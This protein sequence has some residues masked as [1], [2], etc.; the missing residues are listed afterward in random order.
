MINFMTLTFKILFT[1][2]ALMNWAVKIH[3]TNYYVNAST[4]NNSNT[5]L[6]AE[7]ALKTLQ[8]A[9]D[10]TVVGDTVFVMNGTY[11][12]DNSWSS[13]VVIETSSGTPD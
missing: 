8:R 5:G 7:K 3:A 11:V 2:F 9:A 12:K 4:G 1:V 10:K 6:S 13:D